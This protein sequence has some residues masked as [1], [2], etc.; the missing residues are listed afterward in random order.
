MSW[1]KLHAVFNYFPLSRGLQEGQTEIIILFFISHYK[2][3]NL[4][5]LF[6]IQ[7]A[8]LNY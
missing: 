4:Y 8:L 3:P 5:F 1:P 6:H 2:D 7:G